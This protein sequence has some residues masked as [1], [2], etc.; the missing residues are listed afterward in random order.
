MERSGS[1]RLLCSSYLTESRRPECLRPCE[2]LLKEAPRDPII[3]P[4]H[5][6]AYQEA[7]RL[8]QALPPQHWGKLN[9]IG[10]RIKFFKIK[11]YLQRL[12][13]LKLFPNNGECPFLG[14]ER[15]QYDERI[16]WRCVGLNCSVNSI[17]KIKNIEQ[18]I[19]LRC[20]DLSSNHIQTIG[21]A[22]HSLVELRELN[23]SNNS[24]V[25]I[26]GL[27]KCPL[28][29]VLNLKGNNIPKIEGFSNARKSVLFR[30]L[31]DLNLG[32][33]HITRVE[34]LNTLPALTT[35]DLSRNDL[36][37]AEELAFVPQLVNLKIGHNQLEDLVEFGRALVGLNRL[38]DLKVDGNPICTKRDY[39]LRVLERALQA[40]LT[41]FER[42]FK[43]L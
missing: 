26:E 6:K 42:P 36:I 37:N 7:S 28:L 30:Y 19:H 40:M 14:H 13:S 12:T 31:N 38:I 21:T 24:I 23:L 43:G 34:H 4:K 25:R 2:I 17:S 10:D 1:D 11:L 32:G 27:E 15:D 8:E 29:V 41:D 18:F 35:L 9:A 5:R 39:R 16:D 33:N 20:L 3:E 22:L